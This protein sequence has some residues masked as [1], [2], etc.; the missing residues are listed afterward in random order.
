MRRY[1]D[2]E[3]AKMH[4]KN[5]GKQAIDSDRSGLDPVDDIVSMVD[6]LESI[7]SAEVQEIRHAYWK[8]QPGKDPE[9]IC[10]ACGREA[11]YQIIGNRWEFENFCPH[12]GAKM[13]CEDGE[14]H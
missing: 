8:R 13:N 14:W 12:C 9:A 1:I 11:V 2:A 6:I 10:S 3:E 4:I 5:Y 7:P